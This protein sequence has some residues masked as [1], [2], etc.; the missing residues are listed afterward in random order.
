MR[1]PVLCR[2]FRQ[3]INAGGE[4]FQ[5]DGAACNDGGGWRL[6]AEPAPDENAPQD[7]LGN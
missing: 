7:L 1:K 3:R 5:W 6:A 4:Q 2:K